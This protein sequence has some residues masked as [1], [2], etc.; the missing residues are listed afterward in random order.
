MS[1]YNYVK[2]NC[3]IT[4][5]DSLWT[6]DIIQF[7][8]LPGSGILKAPENEY[9]KR[10]LY[11]KPRISVLFAFSASGDYLTPF[12]VYPENF[13]HIDG[14]EPISSNTNIESNANECFAPNGYVTC[15]IFESWLTKL[16]LPY[17]SQKK[18]NCLS[19]YLL[20][21]CGK[22]SVVD[23]QNF[24]LSTG[25][26]KPRVNLFAFSSEQQMPFNV[27]FQKTVRKRQVD[28]FHDSWSKCTAK[29]NLSFQ[30]RCK[31]RAQ[32]FNLFTDAFQ[33]CI[34]EVG[35]K[36]DNLNTSS[37]VDLVPT[38]TSFSSSQNDSVLNFKN[39]MIKS[40]E[41][42]HLWPLN[43]DE[44]KVYSEAAKKKL[45]D[46]EKASAD[47]DMDEEDEGVGVGED[48]DEEEDVDEEMDE[49]VED[50]EEEDGEYKESAHAIEDLEYQPPA[51][52][53]DSVKVI[54][55]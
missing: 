37:R 47:D 26:S 11:S 22:L 13:K 8:Y 1:Y 32:F 18:A 29:L 48:E 17:L 44:Y 15:R 33:N 40:F 45:E 34:E 9:S 21:F 2:Q 46:M 23:T 20:L 38:S 41:Q 19:S 42:C 30:F 5:P 10:P 49:E 4:S 27:L 35:N 14:D 43:S 3:K 24:K 54:R 36:E 28:L 12:I 39:K 50:G 52:S 31:N 16:F 55:N 53:A 25:L 51:I 6:F 7:P